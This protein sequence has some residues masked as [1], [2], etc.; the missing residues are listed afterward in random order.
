LMDANDSFARSHRRLKPWPGAK[1]PSRCRRRTSSRLKTMLARL[2]IDHKVPDDQMA[3][4]VLEHLFETPE[5][6]E[7]FSD[8]KTNPL[9]GSAF[10]LAI[11][12]VGERGSGSR[13]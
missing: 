11:D 13:E 7:F 4:A 8:W 5:V 9:L 3:G 1:R 2:C 6:V 10:T 12:W